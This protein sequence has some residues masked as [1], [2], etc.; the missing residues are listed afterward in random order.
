MRKSG[1]ISENSWVS[2][3]FKLQLSRIFGTLAGK[4]CQSVL[5]CFQAV[6]LRTNFDFTFFFIN[7]VA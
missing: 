3:L 5:A 6:I 1:D 2:G 7:V 4:N